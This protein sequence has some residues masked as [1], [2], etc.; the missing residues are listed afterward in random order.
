MPL[1]SVRIAAAAAAAL[2]RDLGN[3]TTL[4]EIGATQVDIAAL[5]QAALDDVCAGGNPRDASVGEIERLY[6]SIL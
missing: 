3:P 1:E 6:Q 5:G 2:T 4:R